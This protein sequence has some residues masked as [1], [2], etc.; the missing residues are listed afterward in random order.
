MYGTSVFYFHFIMQPG[1]KK[2]I[3][4]FFFPS[5]IHFRLVILYFFLIFLFVG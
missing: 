2:K 1:F 4:L 3:T 5:V